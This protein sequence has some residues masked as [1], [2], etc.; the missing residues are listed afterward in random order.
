MQQDV[1]RLLREARALE[2]ASPEAA[3]AAY[4]AILEKHPLLISAHLRLSEVSQQLDQYRRSL[5]EA[6]RAAQCLVRTRRWEA[7]PFVTLRLLSFG[8][9][10]LVRRLIVDADWSQPAV[11]QQSPVLSQHLWLCDAYGE[12]LALIDKALAVV[13]PNPLLSYSKA[14]ALRYA[15]KL[16]EATEE[17]ERCIAIAPDYAPA[18]WSLAY[19]A[20][21]Q[22][23]GARIDRIRS[24]LANASDPDA[25]IHFNYAL[26]KELDDAGDVDS[27]WRA[28]AEG[29][30]LKRGMLAYDAGREANALAALRARIETVANA[31][32]GDPS[33]GSVPLFI[34][35]MPRTGT[36]LLERILSNHGEVS[37]AGELADFQQ[38][39]G[40]AADRFV[41]S[42]PAPAS[43]EALSAVDLA[44]VGRRYLDKTRPYWNGKRFM[45]DKNPAN[46]F[47]AWAI[48][49]AL[50][51]ARILCLVRE[52]MD[53][54]FSNLKELFSGGAYP[55]SYDLT[56]LA[57]H[58]RAFAQ[59]ALHWQKL[60]PGQFMA[61]KYEDLVTDA[62]RVAGEVASFCGL[63]APEGLTDIASNR[64][65]VQTASYAQVRQPIHGR[66]VGAWRRYADQLEPL[67]VALGT[68]LA[69]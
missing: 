21:S 50:P 41:S 5:V 46:V 51:Q 28:L 49:R 68:E 15:G 25:R 53:A 29:A 60:F 61:V 20:P 43:L 64:A 13:A 16:D 9:R 42:P 17:L 10:Q 38:A 63:D 62:P 48:A 52:P 55:Y 67:R 12:A 32:A 58:Y 8:E 30:S 36:T 1:N 4:E 19:H 69:S 59:S 3:V 23:P 44:A 65:A 57:T 47:Q 6:E 11:I 24:A 56:D 2:A 18:H 7:L 39:L 14:N 45:V 31:P 27:A 34:V 40:W 33:D 22:P 26:F 66:N 35:G 37:A 54:C